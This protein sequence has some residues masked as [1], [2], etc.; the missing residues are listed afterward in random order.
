[1]K[2][3]LFDRLKEDRTHGDI[4]LPF[5]YYRCTFSDD[6][7]VLPMH[8]HE[9]AE[10]TIIKEGRA[11]YTID[12]ET[13]EVEQGDL[14]FIS[15]HVL[16]SAQSTSGL[17]MISDTFVFHMDMLVS[18]VMDSCSIKY[19]IPLQNGS[20]KFPSVIKPDTPYYS[21][22]LACIDEINSLNDTEDDGHEL[23][24]KYNL[25]R[26]L[27]LLNKYGLLS[28]KY[29]GTLANQTEEKLKL[30]LQHIENHYSED[31]TIQA[32]ADLCHFSKCHFMNFFKKYV[33]V[34]CMEYII[35]YRLNTIASK[36]SHSGSN[37]TSL[38]LDA[39]FNNISYFNRVFKK[40]YGTTPKKYAGSINLSKH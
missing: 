6:Y 27:Y 34:T 17:K 39:G 22:L 15:P 4:L 29:S 23:L 1:M 36:L 32:L 37:I 30:I 31:L 26:I 35:D 11:N 8:W 38:A 16:H 20:Y 5:Q 10:I 24:L 19:L 25:Y 40:K 7:S 18:K 14:L 28:V 33:G 21:E 13:Y 12:F 2:H 3:A 9:E